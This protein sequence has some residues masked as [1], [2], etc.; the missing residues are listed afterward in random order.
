VIAIA[1]DVGRKE[2][3]EAILMQNTASGFALIAIRKPGLTPTAG[4]H[5]SFT[6]TSQVM[7]LESLRFCLCRE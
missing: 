7:R 5:P 2:N 4:V 6:L 1:L 3:S